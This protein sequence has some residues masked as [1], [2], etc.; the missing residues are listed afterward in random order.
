MKQ[1][2]K[3]LNLS[4]IT[5]IIFLTSLIFSSCEYIRAKDFS[6]TFGSKEEVLAPSDTDVMLELPVY[7]S[8]R[9]GQTIYHCGYTVNFNPDWLIPNWVAYELTEEEANGKQGRADF[10]TEDPELDTHCPSY[11]DYSTSEYDRGHMAPAGDMKWDQQAMEEC[12]FMTNICPQDHSL[13]TGDWRLLEEQ[14]R[15][16]ALKYDNIYVVC[17]PIVS[18]NPERIGRSGVAVPDAFYKVVLCKIDGKWQALGFLFD[19]DESKHHALKTYCHSVDHVEHITG[20]DFFSALDDSVENMIEADY[21]PRI[22]GL[23]D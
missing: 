12:F 5:F 17:G 9:T 20:I 1:F 16:W 18:D 15:R 8:T 2:F 14:I 4:K 23:S 10:F 22:W 3:P 11:K 7:T 21:N 13:N 19:N 6:S